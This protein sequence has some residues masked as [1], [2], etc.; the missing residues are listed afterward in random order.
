[1]HFL[2]YFWTSWK[3]RV[4][5]EVHWEAG[6]QGGKQ[7]SGN[8]ARGWRSGELLL[9][10]LVHR[11]GFKEKKESWAVHST[12]S[13]DHSKPLTS[14]ALDL[15]GDASWYR[16][17]PS[18]GLSWER[19][20]DLQSPEQRQGRWGA[21]QLSSSMVLGCVKAGTSSH[22]VTHHE[23]DLI[24]NSLRDKV[25]ELVSQEFSWSEDEILKKH[26][27]LEKRSIPEMMDRSH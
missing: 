27:Y 1:M 23:W 21:S 5:P 24:I 10:V 12:T 4:S 7:V 22:T 20:W 3:H 6:L 19:G 8:L 25:E 14:P 11:E 16:F 18:N 9:W 26:F 17:V 13:Q 15:P 2:G